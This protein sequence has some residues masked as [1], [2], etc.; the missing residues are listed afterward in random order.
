[1]DQTKGED[2]AEFCEKPNNV[3]LNISGYLLGWNQQWV[4][5]WNPVC[6]IG[7]FP[8]ELEEGL[9]YSGKDNVDDAVKYYQSFFPRDCGGQN[10]SQGPW[11]NR[12]N[13][14]GRYPFSSQHR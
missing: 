5:I 14:Q 6:L 11:S 12:Q 2:L 8:D 3:R 4:K 13:F 1:M 7:Y 9:L 10:G